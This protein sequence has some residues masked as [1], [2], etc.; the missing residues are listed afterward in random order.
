MLEGEKLLRGVAKEKV[1][2]HGA[3]TSMWTN[4]PRYDNG[5]S[6][7]NFPHDLVT[8]EPNLGSFLSQPPVRLSFLRS[9]SCECFLAAAVTMN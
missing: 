7:E 3:N 1:A 6:L 8:R 5:I 4:D 2:K 9:Y